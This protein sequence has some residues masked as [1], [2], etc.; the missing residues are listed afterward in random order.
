MSQLKPSWLCRITSYNVC[1]TKLLRGGIIFGRKGITDAYTTG[2]GRIKVRAKT[3]IEEKKSREVIIIDE[4][5]YQVN[6]ARL[7]ENIAQLVKDKQIE[8]ISEIRDESDREGMRVV[9][10]N[11]V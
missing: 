10:N 1:Y 4:L 3:H 6:K 2:R 11:F 9:R 7:I 5:P 8:G